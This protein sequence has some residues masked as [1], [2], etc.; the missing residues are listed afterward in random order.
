MNRLVALHVGGALTPWQAIGLTFDE[1]TCPLADVDIL[2]SGETP[3][4]HGWT[5]DIGRDDVVD[6]DGIR[7]TLVSGTQPRPSLSKIGRQKVIGLDHVVVNTD[8]I[9]RT[10]QAIT[11]ALG[12]EVRR[13]RQ[14][15]NGAVQR[16]HKLDNTIIEVVTGPHITQPGASLWGMVASVD[17]LFDL[18]EELGENTTS[19]PKKA[20]QPGRYISTVRGSVGLGVPF[21]LMTPHVRPP[22][23]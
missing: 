20:T 12:L 3:G 7:T 14:L 23:D 16:F 9:D 5:I 8:D 10:T 22:S 17:D 2:V 21:A 11:A 4:L 18:A 6:I 1:L 19:P 15:V 13:E